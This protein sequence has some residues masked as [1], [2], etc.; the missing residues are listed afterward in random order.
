MP[1]HFSSKAL[2]ALAVCVL[3]LS[4]QAQPLPESGREGAVRLAAQLA[5]GHSPAVRDFAAAK[6]AAL[7]GFA[8]RE[9]KLQDAKG[10]VS[11]AQNIEQLKQCRQAARQGMLERRLERVERRGS[12]GPG[13]RP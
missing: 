13:P 1:I 2:A 7:Q 8:R 10:C 9:Q 3:S 12:P 6:D 11:A 5:P 4:A